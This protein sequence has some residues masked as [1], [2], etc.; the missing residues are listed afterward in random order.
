[1]IRD[2]LGQDKV[3][4]N[5]PKYKS[6]YWIAGVIL[7]LLAL[8]VLSFAKFK[9]LLS[10]D[11]VL[12]KN[13]IQT[14]TVT[15]GNLVE[16]IFVQGKT[17]AAIN[18]AVYAIA[19]GTVTLHVKAG[20][21]ISQGQQLLTIDSPELRNRLLQEEA[22]LASLETEFN[23]QKITTEQA[24][25]DTKQRAELAK[26]DLEAAQSA[27]NRAQA[28]IDKQI[29]SRLELEE[30]MVALKRAELNQKHAIEALALEQK[31]L[32]F[33][34]KI[35]ELA[36]ARQQHQTA[37]LR[38]QVRELTIQ[39]P[40][41][42]IVGTVSVQQK[43]FV[44]RD[45]ELMSLVDLSELEVEAYI[46]ENLADELAI[47]LQANIL[48]NQDSYPAKLVAISPE[49]EH[50]NLP[51][52]IKLGQF[53]EDLYYRL[54]MIE[55]S[56]P[57]LSERKDDIP[58]LVDKFLPKGKSLTAAAEQQLMTYHWPGNVRELQNVIGRAQLL[59][60]SDTIDVGDLGIEI[61]RLPPQQNPEY[62]QA[63]IQLAIAKHQGVIAKAARSLGLSR[64]A[65]YR[66]MEK[67]G[68][69]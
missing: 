41:S 38:R 20:D 34:L 11:L 17:L 65:F 57:A 25:L 21:T 22:S 18:P 63:E 28:S 7:G 45:S 2:T 68:L 42:G 62:S 56:L 10:T 30:K 33:E 36:L 37:E 16:D 55:L 31:N 60:K 4:V 32:N 47:G 58:L 15:R 5:K 61:S 40:L 50:S 6:K 66:R 46:P 9:H 14:A 12:V 8:S 26:V 52:A 59:A 64:Q 1:M 43:Q 19:A 24:L 39:S 48:I 23:R 35:A 67:Y 13:Q 3:L 49:V 44:Q 29:I 27:M 54:N 51:E 69:K 53:R